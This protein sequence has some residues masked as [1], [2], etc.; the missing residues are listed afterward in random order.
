VVGK[1]PGIV[2]TPGGNYILLAPQF[3][4]T[5]SIEAIEFADTFVLYPN[6][7]ETSVTIGN[8]MHEFVEHVLLL[9]MQGR[10]LI[11]QS[12][13][14][15]EAIEIDIAT[16]KSGIYLVQLQGKKKSTLRRLLKN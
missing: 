9:D 10:R 12:V 14:S 16:L 2:K 5:T 7:A 13:H 11:H 3:A 6:P 15:S 4:A 1:D 8:P